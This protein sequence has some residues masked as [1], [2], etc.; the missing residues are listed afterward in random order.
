M[1]GSLGAPR[2]LLRKLRELMA[3]TKGLLGDDTYRVRYAE[4]VDHAKRMKKPFPC[5]LTFPPLLG[6]TP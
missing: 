2:I 3:E 6:T 1:R 5:R 4:C